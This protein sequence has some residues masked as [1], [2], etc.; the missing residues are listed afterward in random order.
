MRLVLI[1]ES[2]LNDTERRRR[3]ADREEV[4]RHGSPPVNPF[5]LGTD[6]HHW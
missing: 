3:P 4:D 6:E 1:Y 5:R 2:D